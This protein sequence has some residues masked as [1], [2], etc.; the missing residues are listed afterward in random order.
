MTLWSSENSDLVA[1]P[2]ARIHMAEFRLSGRDLEKWSL[3][4]ALILVDRQM[5]QVC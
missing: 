5:I 2:Y 1:P 3:L 4:G